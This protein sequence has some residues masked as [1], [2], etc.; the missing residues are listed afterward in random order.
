MLMKK[1]KPPLICLGLATYLISALLQTSVREAMK[2]NF[3]EL[4]LGG[5]ASSSTLFSSENVQ[6]N[7]QG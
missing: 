2:N 3:L 6:L 1:K 5:K 7:L 4:T